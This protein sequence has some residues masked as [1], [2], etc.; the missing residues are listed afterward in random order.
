VENRYWIARKHSAM[1]M[2][3]AAATAEARLIHFE[4]AG[5][6]SIKAAQFPP[7]GVPTARLAARGE[8]LALHL[9][10]PG[11]PAPLSFRAQGVAS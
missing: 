5:R 1:T 6:Y 3:Q 7:L 9:P 2:A 10:P 11:A 4:L 8:G